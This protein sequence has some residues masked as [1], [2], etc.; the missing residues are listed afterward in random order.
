[1]KIANYVISVASTILLF[2]P[3]E[4]K[5]KKPEL[6]ECGVKTCDW[7]KINEKT[8]VK[9]D[10][11]ASLYKVE[12][13]WGES[14]HKKG[15]APKLFSKKVPIRWRESSRDQFS[16][17]CYNKLPVYIIGNEF[18][19]LNFKYSDTHAIRTAAMEYVRV[20]YDAPWSAAL[21]GTCLK[22]HNLSEL[23]TED[24][25]AKTPEDLFQYVK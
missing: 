5:E 11:G 24:V 8:L 25:S 10:K 6:F 15:R 19:I 4:A 17:F 23:M 1:M 22:E 2:H 18:N 16:V 20:C 12:L 9:Q 3:A 14:S 13:I 7:V 21:S